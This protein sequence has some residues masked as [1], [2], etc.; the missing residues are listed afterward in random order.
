MNGDLILFACI[1]CGMAA[2]WWLGYIQGRSAGMQRAR[3]LFDEMV[4]EDL[5]RRRRALDAS[6]ITPT[7]WRKS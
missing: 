5:E 4:R 2:A 3:E 1:F 7:P 6:I